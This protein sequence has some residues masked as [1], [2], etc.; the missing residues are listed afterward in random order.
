[1]IDTIPD[2]DFKNFDPKITPPLRSELNRSM[3]AVIHHF[4]LFTDGP[5]VP[6]GEV[7]VP[8]ESPRGELG[9]FVAS[10]G[11]GRPWR[12]HIR[13]PSFVNLQIVPLISKDYLLA[14]LIAILA[15]LDP[16]MGDVDR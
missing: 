7:Y 3:E 5:H 15:T 8:V 4:K 11:R 6:A 2:G 1:V 13:G 10:D 16:V 14:D 12:L 9:Y